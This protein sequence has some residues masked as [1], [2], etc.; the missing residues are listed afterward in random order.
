MRRTYSTTGRRTSTIGIPGTGLY[1]VSYSNSKSKSTSHGYYSHK[2][3]EYEKIADKQFPYEDLYELD[4]E[5]SKNA[6]E[7]IEL[8][9]LFIFVFLGALFLGIFSDFCKTVFLIVSGIIFI[10]Y[11]VSKVKKKKIQDRIKQAEYKNESIEKER[12]QFIEKKLIE[13]KERVKRITKTKVN[14][15]EYVPVS[16]DLAPLTELTTPL[17]T[18]TTSRLRRNTSALR[19]TDF[20]AISI[21]TTGYDYDSDIIQINAVRFSEMKPKSALFSL[22]KPKKPLKKSINGITNSIL[23]K[24]PTIEQ[25]LPNLET[26]VGNSNIVGYNTEFDLRLLYRYGYDFTKLSKRKYY[27]VCEIAK[28]KI[29]NDSIRYDLDNICRYYKID[30]E[31]VPKTV[32]DSIAIGELFCRILKKEYDISL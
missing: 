18:I 31:K 2:L 4:E 14:S 22:V 9:V 27:D 5:L 11:I 7:S 23:E 13:E 20:V 24:E 12:R 8:F 30:Y 16:L 17:T 3:N 10:L 15:L 1:S 6:D 26:F 32:S 28:S 25:V 21:E 29:K 19:F